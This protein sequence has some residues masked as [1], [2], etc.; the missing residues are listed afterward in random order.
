M[1][2]KVVNKSKELAINEFALVPFMEMDKDHLSAIVEGIKLSDYS[3]NNYKKDEDGTDLNQVRILIGKDLDTNQN[4]IRN[5][6]VL[7][8]AV[9]FTA[10]LVICHQMTVHQKSLQISQ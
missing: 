7:S 10:T 6:S 9:I 2:G 3:F 4:A 1:T 8:D 5:S